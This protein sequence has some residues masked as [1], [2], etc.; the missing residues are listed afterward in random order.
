MKAV[1]RLSAMLLFF[2]FVFPVHAKELR[3][4]VAANVQ[5][6]IK[7][8]STEFQKET[9][10]LPLVSLGSSG[11]LTAQISNGAPFDVFLSANMKYPET[12]YKNGLA[13]NA[14]E[15]YARGAVVYWTMNKKYIKI[16][17]GKASLEFLNH[18]SIKKIAI[19]NPDLAPYGLGAVTSLKHFNLY[20][21]LSSK[22]VIAENISQANQ[23]I[24]SRNVEG[25]FTSKS[26]VVSPKIKGQG[27][28]VDLPAGSYTPIDQGAVILKYGEKNHPSEAKKFYDFLFTPKT[29]SIL[30]RYGYLVK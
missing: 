30:E 18:S 3:I 5:F 25:G 7:E 20:D 6:A 2:V 4:A 10:I 22:L 17:D 23:Y 24:I 28:W 19:P 29:K 12:L 15:V 26:V 1:Y 11:K 8:I 27:F 21:N 14:P 9:G 13:I 16:N